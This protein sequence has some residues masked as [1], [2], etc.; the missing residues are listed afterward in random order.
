[1]GHHALSF[2]QALRD[3]A[4]WVVHLVVGVL[5]HFVDGARHDV[6]HVLQRYLFTTI[7]T[8]V[9]GARAYTDNPPLRHMTLGVALAMDVLLVAVLIFGLLRGMFEHTSYRARYS[10]KVLLPKLLVAVALV[11]FSLPLTQMAID[12]DNALGHVAIG[13]GD[14]MHV[15]GLPW[16]SS[17]S[18]PLIANMSASQDVFH[19]VFVVAMV[20]ALVMLVLAYVVR[21]ALLAVLIVMSPLA[22]VCTILPDTRSYARTWLRLFLVTVFMQAVQLVVLRVAVTFAFD[23]SGF[24]LVQTFYGIATLFLLLKVPGALNTASHLETKGKT[25]GHHLERA[26]GHAVHPAHR[27]A[28]AAHGATHR[29]S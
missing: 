22:A 10:L 19:A 25:L 14:G 5:T 29:S 15:D 4:G 17:L 20:I 7:D 27:A 1:V 8:S 9:A 24:G 11:H 6:E 18:A 28:S 2:L 16:S 23:N 26:I 21:Y 13:L 3:P 12:L